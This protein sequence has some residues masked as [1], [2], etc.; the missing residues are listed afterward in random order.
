MLQ[1]IAHTAAVIQKHFKQLEKAVH[2]AVS[3]NGLTISFTELSSDD[4]LRCNTVTHLSK[5][6]KKPYH[7]TTIEKVK[8][9]VYLTLTVL[10]IVMK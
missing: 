3:L 7:A 4:E 2:K 8:T 1:T 5:Q 10:S 9:C 6:R